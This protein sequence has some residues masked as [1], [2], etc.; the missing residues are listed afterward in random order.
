MHSGSSAVIG[1][2]SSPVVTPRHHKR[3]FLSR[4]LSV[5]NMT[6]AEKSQ[7][8]GHKKKTLNK[9]NAATTIKSFFR[10]IIAQKKVNVVRQRK[11]AEVKAKKKRLVVFLVVGQSSENY[12]G[13]LTSMPGAPHDLQVGK[14]FLL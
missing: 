13:P 5:P 11:K 3:V 9:R 1:D 4:A 14:V 10:M 6:Y 8:D 2:D 12:S 7:K